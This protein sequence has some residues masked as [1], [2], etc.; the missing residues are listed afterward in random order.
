MI[1]SVDILKTTLSRGGGVARGNKFLVELPNFGG[2][3]RSM[4]ILCREA[5]MPGRQIFTSDRRMG[6]E[7]EKIAYGYSNDD[8]NLVFYMPNSYLPKQYFDTWESLILDRNEQVAA[9]KAD[10]QKRVI[11]HQL[12]DSLPNTTHNIKMGPVNIK[13]PGINNII[14]RVAT[15]NNINISTTAYSVELIDAFPTYCSPVQFTNDPDALVQLNVTLSYTNWRSVKASQI[16]FK[17]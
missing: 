7:F 11:I 6:M 13:V 4:N 16:T 8:V 17:L 14:N 3:M 9:Y 1:G 10:Y 2:T 12:R 5:N 15:K